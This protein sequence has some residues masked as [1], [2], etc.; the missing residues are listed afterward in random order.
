[1]GSALVRVDRVGVGVHR[2]GVGVRPLHRDLERDPTLG[3][4][5][6]E[7]DDLGVDHLGF[8]RR[9]QILDVV[10]E[11]LL[12]EEHVL[13]RLLAL[14]DRAL[15]GERDREALVQ[16]GHL[17]EAGAQRVVVE[18]DGFE[19][20]GVRPEGDGGSGAVGVAGV[21]ERRIRNAVVVALG[22]ERALA[23]NRDFELVRERVDDGAAD[24]VQTAGD[25]VAA[26]AE[27]SAGVQDC[28]H[29]LDR[30][31]LLDR[32]LVDGDAA[33]VVDDAH[34][35]IGEDRD[36]DAIAVPGECLINGVVDDLVDEV[37]K[38][39]RTGRADVHAGSLADRLESFED[40]DLIRAVAV[41][42][43]RRGSGWCHEKGL[44]LPDRRRRH[45]GRTDPPILPQR[46]YRRGAKRRSGAFSGA[47]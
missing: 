23:A 26:A 17:L 42:A 6:L 38:T 22:P 18:F 1:M 27:L 41:V 40:L 25:G 37:V 32:V 13:A 45:E 21:G 4:L 36:L 39:A 28:E 3:V 20:V 8:L 10:D 44:L 2:L 16:E 19:D 15:V 34:G 9:V 29:D 5:R 31:L 24:A 47:L 14:G 33:A 11:S 35:A 46:G 12:V 30:R 43:G 7:A